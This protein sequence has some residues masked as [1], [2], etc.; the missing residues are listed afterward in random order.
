MTF[1]RP[2][3]GAVVALPFWCATLPCERLSLPGT[4]LLETIAVRVFPPGCRSIC[5][6]NLYNPPMET[7]KSFSF[8]TAIRRLGPAAIIACDLNLHH[9]LWDSHIYHQRLEERTLPLF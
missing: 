6:V 9:E 5:V 4:D 2:A 1:F 3:L 7:V 8:I